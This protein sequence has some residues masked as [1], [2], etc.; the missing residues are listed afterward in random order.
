MM[1]SEAQFSP[2]LRH[3]ATRMG[4]SDA[5]RSVFGNAFVE[6]FVGTRIWEAQESERFVN[7][8]QLNRYLEI[9]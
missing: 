7:D 2:T 9:I 3:A 4:G 5:A 6:H 8:W 1:G